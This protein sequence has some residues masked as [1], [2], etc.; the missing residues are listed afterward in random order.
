[1]AHMPN[2]S[3]TDFVLLCL[4]FVLYL[5][6]LAYVDWK[7]LV[8]QLL[9]SAHEDSLLCADP[10]G[11]GSVFTREGELDFRDVCTVVHF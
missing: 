6:S 10:L 9:Q 3:I 11:S 4:D 1:V 8:F 2:P 5:I 7:S